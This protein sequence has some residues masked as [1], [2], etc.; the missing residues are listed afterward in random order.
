MHLSK[1][2]N[3]D[4]YK[5]D[6][7]ICGSKMFYPLLT[8]YTFTLTSREIKASINVSQSIV[9]ALISDMESDEGSGCEMWLSSSGEIVTVS[10]TAIAPKLFQINNLRRWEI[11][12]ANS[13]FSIN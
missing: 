6:P 3:M 2:L 13:I 1:K 10:Q 7:I 11:F 9:Q 5:L 4:H 8:P 12:S